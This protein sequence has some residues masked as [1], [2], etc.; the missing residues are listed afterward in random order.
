MS[1]DYLL[2]ITFYHSWFILFNGNEE[3]KMVQFRQVFYP[4]GRIWIINSTVIWV[5]VRWGEVIV[6][7]FFESICEVMYVI[8]SPSLLSHFYFI[9]YL[10]INKCY[11]TTFVLIKHSYLECWMQ[12]LFGVG[13]RRG[14]ICASWYPRCQKLFELTEIVGWNANKHTFKNYSVV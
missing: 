7:I 11:H 3:L 14:N 8:C 9:V 12:A 1:F 5:E 10:V 6:C 13:T 4:S 2:F